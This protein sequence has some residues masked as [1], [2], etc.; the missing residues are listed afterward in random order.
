MQGQPGGTMN[1]IWVVD[2][3][4]SRHMTG[5]LALLHDLREF[6]GGFVNFAGDK[7]GKITLQGTVTNG[8]SSFE[9]VNFVKE[10]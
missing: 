7:G 4:C 6:D 9:Q 10:L 2:S 5:N 3:G 8:T 1:S